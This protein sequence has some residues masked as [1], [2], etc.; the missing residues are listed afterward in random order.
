VFAICVT[1]NVTQLQIFN[2]F[3]YLNPLTIKKH[4]YFRF[5]QSVKKGGNIFLLLMNIFFFRMDMFIFQRLSV[6]HPMV[7]FSENKLTP[8]ILIEIFI[9]C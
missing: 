9:V 5:V 8:T 3:N 2:Y 4:E 6:I 1:N 7:L